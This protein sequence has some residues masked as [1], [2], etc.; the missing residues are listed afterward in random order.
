MAKSKRSDAEESDAKWGAESQK[1]QKSG[2]GLKRE[3]ALIFCHPFFS[4]HCFS[5]VLSTLSSSLER[6]TNFSVDT[7]RNSSWASTCKGTHGLIYFSPVP[8]PLYGFDSS[9]HWSIAFFAL[10][11]IY[12]IP[13]RVLL[14]LEFNTITFKLQDQR[15]FEVNNVIVLAIERKRIRH[16]SFTFVFKILSPNLPPSRTVANCGSYFS[17]AGLRDRVNCKLSSLI[18]DFNLHNALSNQWRD[19]FL[20]QWKKGW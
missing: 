4:R 10:V 20:C 6:A 5:F 18:A 19:H 8:S 16:F 9:V 12:L 13:E 7:C 11:R 1:Q 15:Q 17:Q 14:F 2:R 3:G